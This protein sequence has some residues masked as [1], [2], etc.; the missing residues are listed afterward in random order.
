MYSLLYGMLLQLLLPVLGGGQAHV[1]VGTVIGFTVLLVSLTVHFYETHLLAPSTMP[2]LID[3]LRSRFKR[4][5]FS[6]PAQAAQK[7]IKRRNALLARLSIALPY[8]QCVNY[9]PFSVV[10]SS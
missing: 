1:L 8:F 3:K 5:S 4:D 10:L 2:A 7:R 6:T 9:P